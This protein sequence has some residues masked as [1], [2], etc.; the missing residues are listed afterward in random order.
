[1]TTLNAGLVAL[2]FFR[3]SRPVLLKNPIFCDF[4]GGG[5]RPLCPLPLWIRLWECIF[6]LLQYNFGKTIVD[7]GTTNLRLPTRVFNSVLAKMKAYLKVGSILSNLINV[8]IEKWICMLA[9][10]F[11]CLIWFVTSTQQSFSYA[12]RFFLGWT[13]TKLG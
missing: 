4:S 11:V 2:W 3:G 8:H 10:T 9:A 1:M 13:S 5:S 12:G 7:S 6:S